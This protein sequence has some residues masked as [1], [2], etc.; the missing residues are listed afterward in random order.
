M[1][2][3]HWNSRDFFLRVNPAAVK[4]EKTHR[5]SWLFLLEFK[6]HIISF[7]GSSYE[8]RANLKELE[9]Y[10][11]TFNMSPGGLSYRT[12][13]DTKMKPENDSLGKDK[14]GSVPRGHPFL[15]YMTIPSSLLKCRD[16]IAK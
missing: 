4:I 16:T 5:F 10:R 1:I 2:E 13:M 9:Q 12:Y 14:V 15:R 7:L 11:N 6:N 8:V 3:A